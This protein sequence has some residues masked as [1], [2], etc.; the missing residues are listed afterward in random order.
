[1]A[2]ST[3]ASQATGYVVTATDWNTFVSNWVAYETHAHTGTSDGAGTL[4]LASGAVGAPSLSFSGDTNLGIWRVGADHIAVST[5]GARR[6]GIDASGNAYIGDAS[7]ALATS[8]T[9]GFLHIPTAAGIPTG[10]PTSITGVKPMMMNTTNHRL[11]VYSGAWRTVGPFGQWVSSDDTTTNT[12][13]TATSISIAV[14]S[15]GRYH[16]EAHLKVGSS[17]AAGC[18]YAVDVPASATFYAMVQGTTS[19]ATAFTEELITG[20]GTLTTTAFNTA[21]LTTAAVGAFIHIHGI[22]TMGGTAGNIV[23]QHAKV[24]SGTSTVYTGSWGRIS[25]QA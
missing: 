10:T 7:A 5:A 13:A 22:V 24:T 23:I 25:E 4:T 8:A 18:K 21:G 16:F 2:Y 12:T 9:D 17:T 19:A 3:P 15:Y 1:M 6:A 14:P 20:D 11:N